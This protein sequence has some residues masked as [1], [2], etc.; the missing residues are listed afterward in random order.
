MCMR[1]LPIEIQDFATIREVEKRAKGFLRRTEVFGRSFA[2]CVPLLLRVQ[3]GWIRR[4]GARADRHEKVPVALG[5]KRKKLFKIGVSFD[6]GKRNI[7]K[8]KHT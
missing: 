4:R 1:R 5:G 7:G 2:L 6:S 3:T 8:W